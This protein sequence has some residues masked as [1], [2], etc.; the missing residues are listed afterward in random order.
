MA[1]QVDDDHQFAP[2]LP[3]NVYMDIGGGLK[4][5]SVTGC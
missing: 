4:S 2:I 1:V 3:A 5:N